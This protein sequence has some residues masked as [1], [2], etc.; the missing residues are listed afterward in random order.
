MTSRAVGS[1]TTD[2]QKAW[3]WLYSQTARASHSTIA[4]WHAILCTHDILSILPYIRY[5]FNWSLTDSKVT[6]PPARQISNQN[7]FLKSQ[8]PQ[9]CPMMMMHLPSNGAVL[10]VPLTTA[11]QTP[12]CFRVI[13]FSLLFESPQRKNDP[14]LCKLLASFVGSHPAFGRCLQSKSGPQLTKAGRKPGYYQ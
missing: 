8:L 7:C 14:I 9:A 13:F 2:F 12:S 3:L 5:L 1:Q 10:W 6:I 11:T 4:W